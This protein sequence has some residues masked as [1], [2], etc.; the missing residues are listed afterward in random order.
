MV[1]DGNVIP[2]SSLCEA[3]RCLADE[4][5]DTAERGRATAAE[6]L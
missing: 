1:S 3:E 6:S 4:V 5:N 2:S